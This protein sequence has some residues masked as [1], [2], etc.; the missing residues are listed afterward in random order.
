M[1]NGIFDSTGHPVR[2]AIWVEIMIT[3]PCIPLG[4]PYSAVGTIHIIAPD[5]NRGDV[6]PLKLSPVGT[7]H[8]IAPDFNRGN[9]LRP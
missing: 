1:L 3:S 5:F 4:M 6:S 8:I 9:V 7:E 2:D